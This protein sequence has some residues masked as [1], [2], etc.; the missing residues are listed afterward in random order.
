MANGIPM[1]F[2]PSLRVPIPTPNQV[3]PSTGGG[4]PLPQGAPT[5]ISPTPPP[6]APPLGGP[7]AG[8]ALAQAPT[9]SMSFTP[10]EQQRIQQRTPAPMIFTPAEQE[11]IQQRPIKP[12]FK[13]SP[14]EIEQI[15]KTLDPERRKPQF[16]FS[17]DELKE[18]KQE[19]KG[20]IDT[21]VA[22]KKGRKKDKLAKLKAIADKR[23][24]KGTDSPG[25]DFIEAISTGG[26]GPKMPINYPSTDVFLPMSALPPVIQE[27]AALQG[28]V[29]TKT[30]KPVI[31]HGV[32][33]DQLKTEK[34]KALFDAYATKYA[35]QRGGE[36]VGTLDITTKPD[37]PTMRDQLAKA[38][39]KWTPGMGQLLLAQME[40]EGK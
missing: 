5:G 34:A 10:E 27:H 15:K 36:D 23:M 9:D 39:K 6:V 17:P 32:Y 33:R 37:I 38:E 26:M 4:L 25:G 22:K 1:T 14:E 8:P 35:T 31:P 12:D 19:M 30:G 7:G 2:D 13:F 3:D 18:L 29:D 24:G 16:Y 40:K 11:S 20:K 21:A 28:L